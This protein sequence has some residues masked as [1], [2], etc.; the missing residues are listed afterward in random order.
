MSL[1]LVKSMLSH[2]WTIWPRYS[3]SMSVACKG[4]LMVEVRV[5]SFE[6]VVHVVRVVAA[7]LDTT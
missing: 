7:S 3:S 1:L 5:R 4:V 6:A 2:A